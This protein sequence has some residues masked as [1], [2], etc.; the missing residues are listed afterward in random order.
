L[1]LY[2]LWH[3]PGRPG[4]HGLVWVAEPNASKRF[5]SLMIEGTFGGSGTH[6]KRVL[7]GEDDAVSVYRAGGS[8]GLFL[9]E[10]DLPYVPLRWV[11]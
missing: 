1:R 2:V 7:T 8:R 11:V 5:Q 4:F 6:L 9:R 3:M 10:H